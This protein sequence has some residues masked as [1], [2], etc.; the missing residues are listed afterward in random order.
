MGVWRLGGALV[1]G[2]MVWYVA[3]M[4]W[5]PP[6]YRQRQQLLVSHPPTNLF[7]A[8]GLN[9]FTNIQKQFS[10]QLIP[11]I[12]RGS[13]PL[14]TNWLY[15]PWLDLVIVLNHSGKPELNG[16]G[17]F[18]TLAKGQ[19]PQLSITREWGSIALQ[20]YR[21][22]KTRGLKDFNVQRDMKAVL[23]EMDQ[24]KHNQAWPVSLPVG[25]H[26]LDL[27]IQPPW[28]AIYCDRQNPG[29]YAIV[30]QFNHCYYTNECVLPRD[31]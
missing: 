7:T 21:Q 25:H 18:N 15:N 30:N 29:Q 3:R 2:L 11:Y 10:D 6:V 22:M 16:L 14:R 8:R 12:V 1:L 4:R 24:L 28:Y 27:Y 13:V 31:R 23:M 9:Q 20:R 19:K 5:A 17:V 26:T